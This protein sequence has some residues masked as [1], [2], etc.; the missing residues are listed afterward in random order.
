M[1]AL[2]PPSLSSRSSYARKFQDAAFWQPYVDE[3][4]RRHNLPSGLVACQARIAGWSQSSGK[5]QRHE[6]VPGQIGATRACAP[7]GVVV[8]GEGGGSDSHACPHP[9]Q[10]G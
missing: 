3:V 7:G 8:E 9:A 2:E 1:S 6:S 4:M 5:V 10:G